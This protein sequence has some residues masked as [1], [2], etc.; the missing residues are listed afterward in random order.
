MFVAMTEGGGRREGGERERERKRARER[1]T[2]AS[3]PGTGSINDAVPNHMPTAYS[4]G[5]LSE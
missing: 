5:G 1:S 3:S 2:D 4:H